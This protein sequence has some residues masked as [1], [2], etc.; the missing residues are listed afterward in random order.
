M[1]AKKLSVLLSHKSYS[2][3]SS[4]IV[5]IIYLFTC[6]DSITTEFGREYVC[7]VIRIIDGDSV[8]AV[9]DGFFDKTIEIRLQHIDAPE[10]SQPTWGQASA[11]QLQKIVQAHDNRLRVQFQGKDI[12]QRH[13]GVLF[14]PRYNVNVMMLEK[15][16][17]RV[18]RRYQPPTHYI[19]AMSVAKQRG[20][21][22]WQTKGLQQDPQRYR[23][24]AQ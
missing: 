12:Y 5:V 22:I 23:R 2:V 11:N 15:G 16:M 10:I 3:I 13:L 8:D 7:Q 9:C 4:V 21:G 18:Y 24:L 20:V 14:T 19:Q 6:P 17:A 1:L